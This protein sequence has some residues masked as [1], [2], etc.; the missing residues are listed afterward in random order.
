MVRH[1]VM[2]KLK[3]EAP[4]GTFE[5]LSIG[6]S[7]LAES[8][9]AISRYSYG[10]DLGLREGNFEFVVVADFENADAYASYLDH[11]DHL[12][13]VENQLRP[14]VSERVAVQFEF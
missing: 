6:L 7:K 1:V 4:E 10:L 13:F 5:S 2:F 12:D 3:D 14:V 8:I 11:P 9:S